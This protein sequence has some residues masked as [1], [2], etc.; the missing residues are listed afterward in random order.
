MKQQRGFNRRGPLRPLPRRLKRPFGRRLRQL[1][2]NERMLSQA[3]RKAERERGLTP[4]E[5]ILS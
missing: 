3:I 4:L 5:T 2:E 1:V